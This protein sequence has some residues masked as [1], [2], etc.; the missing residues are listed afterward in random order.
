M[1][2]ATFE[3]T[4]G[5]GVAA[6]FAAFAL[7]AAILMALAWP[8][9]VRASEILIPGDYPTPG[10]GERVTAET[11]PGAVVRIDPAAVDIA[12]VDIAVEGEDLVLRLPDGG[13]IV[14]AGF[15]RPGAPE[16]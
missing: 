1:R 2:Q 8:T 15:L 5:H 13:A 12:S 11:P 3:T 9:S 14:L 10:P 6:A 4:R 7:L 16:A